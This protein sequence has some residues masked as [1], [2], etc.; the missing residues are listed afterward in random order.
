MNSRP[1]FFRNS[2]KR[3]K[4][5]S[6]PVMRPK[7]LS[8]SIAKYS[9]GLVLS[10]LTLLAVPSAQAAIYYWDDDAATVGFGTAGAS[11]G[12]W[13][14]PT[15][16]TIAGWSLS[17]TGANAFAAFTTGS[18]DT[19]NF[20]NGATGLAAGT[21]TVSG[22][23]DAGNITF[24]SGS[25]AIVLS[26]DTINLAAAS[27]ITVNNASDTISS[28][29]AGAATSL[30]KAGA[31]TLTLAG[32]NTYTGTTI[33]NGGTV[34]LNLFT[35]SLSSSS[36]LT[37]GGPGTFNMDNTGVAGALAQL[38][39]A[40]TF[41]AGDGTVQITRTE[42]QDQTVTFSSLAARGVG[43]TGNFVNTGGTNSATN[44]IILTGVTANAAMGPGYFFNGGTTNA[45]YAFYDSTGFVRGINWGV[46]SGTT[47]QAGGAITGTA[48]AQSTGSTTA[49]IATGQIF[50]GLN[51]QNTTGIAQA[52]NITGAITTDGILRSGN[53]ASTTTISGGTSI[54]TTTD[55]ADLVIRTDMAN[56][57][58]TITTP[59]LVN[60]ASGLTKSGAGTVTLSAAN[61]YTGQT[62]VTAGTLTTSGTMVTTAV[63]VSSGASF[64]GTNTGAN[65]AMAT[66]A[67]VTN[68]GAMSLA[69]SQTISTLNGATTGATL[70]AARGST[71]NITG[72]GTYAGA[73][74]DVSGTGTGANL[75]AGGSLTLQGNNGYTGATVVSAGATLAVTGSGAVA[76]T[77]SVT[78]NSGA[79]LQLNAAATNAVNSGAAYVSNGGTLSIGL[80]LQTLASMTLG[81]AA[82]STLN[83][84][85]VA[86]TLSFGS[87]DGSTKTALSSSPITLNIDNWVGS[88]YTIGTSSV[89]LD[90]SQSSFIFSNDPGFTLG[91][92]IPGVYFAGYGPGMEVTV[93]VAGGGTAYQIVPATVVPEPATAA[94]LGS[95]ALC[96]L[97]GCRKRRRSPG[98]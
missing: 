40:L 32:A 76:G 64:T 34:T 88:A 7:A 3:R 24:A 23:V 49:T 84:N 79:T 93:Q 92:V 36:A 61:T 75:T 62:N 4:A 59:I 37:F 72:G 42:D 41:S 67:A 55:G 38:L 52:V 11:A 29:L 83:F 20:G 45:N 71:L 13:E 6:A 43:A 15:A 82:S 14:A 85:N 35:G 30:T 97:I 89:T 94:L 46:D 10:A 33:I 57:A 87:L 58:L 98:F 66:N 68:D 27:T 44:G 21:I 53:G 17:A 25:G 5:A 90:P 96:A 60:G 39:A 95:V 1:V 47:T 50:T 78:V 12:T 28:I 74:N 19:L 80:N 86:G 2:R 56:D 70:A 73:I 81:S 9:R 69:A 65:S 51:F 16:G 91:Q 77:S 26:G 22:T 48:Y 54:K 31:G 18:G 63:S 8:G